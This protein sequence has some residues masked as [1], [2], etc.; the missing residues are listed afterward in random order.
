[1]R[2]FV[3]SAVS[4]LGLTVL[5]LAIG[6]RV[7]A[8]LLAYVASEGHSYDREIYILHLERH[9]SLSAS[10]QRVADMSPQVS[11]NGDKLLFRTTAN[12]TAFSLVDLTTWRVRTLPEL[13]AP[14]SSVSV[15]WMED[16]DLIGFMLFGDTYMVEAKFVYDVAHDEIEEVEFDLYSPVTSAFFQYIAPGLTIPIITDEGVQ[17]NQIVTLDADGFIRFYDENSGDP[18]PEYDP[19]F[20]EYATLSPDYEWFIAPLN[21]ETQI[22]LFLIPAWEGEV[23]NLTNDRVQES[24]VIWSPDSRYIAYLAQTGAFREFRIMDVYTQEVV[25]RIDENFVGDRIMWVSG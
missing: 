8:H 24:E 10:Q 12:A 1:M 21:K 5:A 18:P 9:L 14:L 4:L 22:D 13:P 3:L 15:I 2:I 6:D 25:Y 11:P 17:A 16:P 7:P 20:S 23:I 19:S